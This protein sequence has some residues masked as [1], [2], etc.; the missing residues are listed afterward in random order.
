MCDPVTMTA[1]SLGATA[2]QAYSQYTAA[3]GQAR[4]AVATARNNQTIANYNAKVQDQNAVYQDKAAVDALQRGSDDASKAR[5]NYKK[6]NATTR[7][8]AAGTGLLADTGTY[9]DIQDQNTTY[10]ELNTLTA[11]NNAEREAYGYKV[12][13]NDFRSEGIN[14]RLGGDVGVANARYGADVTRQNGLFNAAS[15]LVTGGANAYDRYIYNPS[16]RL[17]WQQPGSRRPGGGTY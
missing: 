14:L 13:A 9:G 16:N 6:A 15:T 5:E 3:Q 10:G 7:A 2:F 1:I 11:L 8:E 4:S 17:P 12:K